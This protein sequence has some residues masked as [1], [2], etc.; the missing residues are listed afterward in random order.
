[1]REFKR[2]RAESQ[3]QFE[4]LE[5]KRQEEHAERQKEREGSK[6]ERAQLMLHV[7]GKVEEQTAFA[8]F[9][10]KRRQRIVERLLLNIAR[11]SVRKRGVVVSVSGFGARLKRASGS[12]KRLASGLPL[13]RPY[14]PGHT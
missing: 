11:S 6:Q 9:S 8:T 3:Q 14:G 4:R 13:S 1:M 5:Q 12:K 10:V 7:E 2:M